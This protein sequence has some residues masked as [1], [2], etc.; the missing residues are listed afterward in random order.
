MSIGARPR[1]VVS[2]PDT[3]GLRE[4][5]AG[6]RVLGR[7]WSLRELRRVLHRARYP[8]AMP[9]RDPRF[10]IWRGAG[11]DTWPD[12]P[13]P[14]RT[15]GAVMALGLAGSAVLLVRIGAV[16]A[17]ESQTFAGRLTGWLL[18]GAAAVQSAGVVSA[19][20][21]WGKRRWKYSGAVTLIGALIALAMSVLL[22]SMWFEAS[23]FVVY[24][25][26]YVALL[27]WSSWASWRLCRHEAWKGLPHPR[28]VVAGLTLSA[29][30]AGV[31]FANTT[32]Y[33]PNARRSLIT[34][35]AKLGEPKLSPDGK[36]VHIPLR[37]S[38]KNVGTVPV[39]IL[40]TIFW[41]IGVKTVLH[42][43]TRLQYWREILA[44]DGDAEQYT[45][46]TGRDQLATGTFG[47]EGSW[48]D[49]GNEHA[50][51]KI[52][53]IPAGVE[54][55]MIEASARAITTRRD[56]GKIAP[57]YGQPQFSWHP[58]SPGF[59][60]CPLPGGD[61]IAFRAR[62]R[63]NNN[64]INVT[65]RARYVTS[66]WQMEPGGRNSEINSVI[67]P[68]TPCRGVLPLKEEPERYGLMRTLSVTSRVPATGLMRPSGAPTP[69]P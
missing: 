65:R 45:E 57:G 42:E 29:V 66:W 35:E 22:L 27:G 48:L 59:S 24:L 49:P 25:P 68:G 32:L 50:E 8:S 44:F 7:V 19:L 18:L 9:L 20:D 37:V 47:T 63:H 39:D 1:V 58:S 5:S 60:A 40:T 34:T 55:S 13:W 31:N 30:L 12:H 36:I 51:D 33:E 52:I 53:Q 61:C 54:Y 46:V 16:D 21:Y 56:R 2:P 4:V 62:I 64:L 28:S 17:F 6:S 3:R 15:A 41:V 14:R 38:I 11:P 23:E 26:V 10:V 43:E 67:G 69:P